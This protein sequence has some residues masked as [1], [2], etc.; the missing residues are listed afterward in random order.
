MSKGA[1]TGLIA[2]IVVVVGLIVWMVVGRV[3]SKET[4]LREAFN[5]LLAAQSVHTKTTLALNLPGSFRGGERPFTS[6]VIQVEGDAAKAADGTPELA[7]TMLIEAKG[8]GNIFF[9]DGDIRLLQDDVLFNLDNLP[10]LLNPSGSLVK[11]WTRVEVP[12]LRT[13]NGEEVKAAL[14]RTGSLVTYAGTDTIDG[15]TLWHYRGTP[16]AEQ[17]QALYE[18]IR[19]NTSDN[20]ALGVVARLIRSNTVDSLDVWVDGSSQQIRRIS[21]HFTRPMSKGETFDFGRLTLDFSD[22]N[23]SVTIDRPETAVSARADVFARIFGS[24]DVEEIQSE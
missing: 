22:Y 23:K 5:R 3:G 9:A 16:T 17:Q 1:R 4:V 20:R 18:V 24:G 19:Q 15:L 10:V 7:G 2:V 12:V 8:R 11:K 21:A 14:I 13:R 6:V